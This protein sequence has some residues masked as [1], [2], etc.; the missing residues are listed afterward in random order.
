MTEYNG[1][2]SSL[3]AELEERQTERFSS[4]E[5]I[6]KDGF[7]R[8]AIELRTL[9]EQGYIPTVVHER[10]VGQIK[11]IHTE[12]MAQYKAFIT[13][14]VRALCMVIIGLVFWLTG[15]KYLAPHMF[16]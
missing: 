1:G 11:E 16:G 7:E 8:L 3:F 14:I 2:H 15:I 12:A 9:R 10:M 6:L 5:L 4:L 13:I